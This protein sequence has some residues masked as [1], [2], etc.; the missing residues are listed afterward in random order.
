[1][2]LQDANDTDGEESK[3]ESGGRNVLKRG[4]KAFV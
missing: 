1:L 3:A 2:R 4:E